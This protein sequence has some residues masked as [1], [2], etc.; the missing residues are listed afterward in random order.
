MFI[1][2]T[3]MGKIMEIFIVIKSVTYDKLVWNFKSNVMWNKSIAQL[4]FFYRKQAK[5]IDLD[6]T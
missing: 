6:F 5:E 1:Y 4:D 2:S 3:N